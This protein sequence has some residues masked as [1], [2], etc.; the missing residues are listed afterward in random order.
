ME[1]NCVLLDTSFFIR[2]LNE[3]DDLHENAMG[4]SDISWSMVS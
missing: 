2:L 4:I 1:Q 3:E